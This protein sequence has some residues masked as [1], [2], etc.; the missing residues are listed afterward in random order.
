MTSV[1]ADP[2]SAFKRCCLRAGRFDGSNRNTYFPRVIPDGVL[3][4]GAPHL[5]V[6]AV[7]PAI[8]F[9]IFFVAW[10]IVDPLW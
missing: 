8:C 3:R 7:S 2:V 4:Y 1:H 5:R 6:W 10:L 9:T